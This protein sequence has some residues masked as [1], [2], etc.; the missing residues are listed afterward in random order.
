MDAIALAAR[1]ESSLPS[2]T[3]FRVS[4]A[5]CCSGDWRHWF[6]RAASAQVLIAM[7]LVYITLWLSVVGTMMAEYCGLCSVDA[8]VANGI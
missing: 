7:L 8:G 2:K 6:L 1:N 3:T 5:R 4:I